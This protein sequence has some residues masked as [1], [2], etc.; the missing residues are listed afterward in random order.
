MLSGN[1]RVIS[2]ALHMHDRGQPVHFLACHT[3]KQLIAYFVS[4][5]IFL[6]HDTSA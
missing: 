3:K 6:E 1:F 5:H 2:G 4:R